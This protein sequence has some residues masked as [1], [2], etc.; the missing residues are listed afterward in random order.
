MTV[1]EV[2]YLSD[3]LFLLILV[4]PRDEAGRPGGEQA[5]HL[6][7]CALVATAHPCM[8]NEGRSQAVLH[9]F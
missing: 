9:S 5:V 3:Y 2:F 8:K 4:T 1:L 6:D 7:F